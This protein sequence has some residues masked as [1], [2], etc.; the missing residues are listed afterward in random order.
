MYDPES[1]LLKDEYARGVGEFM[2]L[3]CQQPEAKKNSKLKCPCSLCRNSHNIRID[4]VWNHLYVNGFMTGYKIWFL[5]GE[6]PDYA[7]TSE[8]Y[9]T[10]ILEESR[11]EV[12][13]GIGT[14]H[15]VNDV[16]G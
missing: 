4:L 3:A 11:T 8:P 5:H 14:V 1:N 10:D 6:R 16:Y 15:M 13:F 9:V 12:D 2:E 7:S